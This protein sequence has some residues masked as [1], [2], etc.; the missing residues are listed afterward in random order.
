MLFDR[1]LL[2]TFCTDTWQATTTT[3][4]DYSAEVIFSAFRIRSD[5]LETDNLT[6]CDHNNLCGGERHFKFLTKFSLFIVLSV[7]FKFKF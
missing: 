7:D 4:A 2:Q 5:R 6:L 1:V 3:S